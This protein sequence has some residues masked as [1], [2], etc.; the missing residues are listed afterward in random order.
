MLS[1]SRLNDRTRLDLR[2][3][4]RRPGCRLLDDLSR[5]RTANG[6]RPGIGALDHIG[7][8]VRVGVNHLVG[9]R[10]I[11]GLINDVIRDLV[12]SLAS[13]RSLIRIRL[14]SGG[15]SSLVSS[16]S[17]ISIRLVS[18]GVSSLVS[19]RSFFS[20]RS[21]IGGRVGSRRLVSDLIG[22]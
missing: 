13:S 8:S 7:I 14:V 18:G 10:L 12:S 5:I 20:S 17:L 11:G 3:R 15:V 1:N 19:G 21:L 16:R 22:V 2:D 6:A 4:T 9:N